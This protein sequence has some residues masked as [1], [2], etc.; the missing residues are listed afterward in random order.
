MIVLLLVTTNVHSTELLK[1]NLR[2]EISIFSGFEIVTS[3]YARLGAFFSNTQKNNSEYNRPKL[4]AIINPSFRPEYAIGIR[5]ESEKYIAFKFTA[6]DSIWVHIQESRE[7]TNPTDFTPIQIGVNVTEKEISKQ[8]FKVIEAAWKKMIMNTKYPEKHFSGLDG[9]AYHFMDGHFRTGWAWSPEPKSQTGYLVKL[10][11]L[12]G[13]FSESAETK[14]IENEL[15]NIATVL[16][17][18]SE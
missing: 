15:L 18:S 7:K 13:Q 11:E 10:T 9:I 12:L 16:F 8:T 14:K 5:F 4:M 6:K 17:N 2:P 3:Y 1:N